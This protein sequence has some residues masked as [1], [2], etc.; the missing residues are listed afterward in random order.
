MKVPVDVF[1]VVKAAKRKENAVD[2]VEDGAGGE[3]DTSCLQEVMDLL[4]GFAER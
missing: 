2:D 4:D 3:V 1:D